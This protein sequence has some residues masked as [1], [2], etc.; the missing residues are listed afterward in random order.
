MEQ[1]RGEKLAVS[2][3]LVPSLAPFEADAPPLARW[4]EAARDQSGEPRATALTELTAALDGLGASHA[5]VLVDL[6]DS[7]RLEGLTAR[8]GRPMKEVAV[9][10]LLAL[11]F[12]HALRVHPETLTEVREGQ[13]LRR[14][15][16]WR[17]VVAVGLVLANVY[18]WRWYWLEWLASLLKG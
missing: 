18:L 6:I 15:L 9:E 17:R 5:D 8:D 2:D 10:R 4:A 1:T 7:E 13:R 16:K 14:Q 11:G 3:E 12:P